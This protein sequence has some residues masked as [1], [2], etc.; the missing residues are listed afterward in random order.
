MDKKG[1]L[2]RYKISPNTLTFEN[3]LQEET[4]IEDLAVSLKTLKNQGIKPP[5]VLDL[6]KVERANSAGILVW[7]KFLMMI[8][9]PYKYVQCPTWL[10]SQF[11][12]IAGYFVNGGFV[13]SIQAPFYNPENEFS[14]IIT[15]KLGIDVPIQENYHEFKMPKRMIEGNEYEPDFDPNRYFSFIAKN[16]KQF[17][18]SIK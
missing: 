1:A 15:L 4:R 17:K 14:K 7:L 10:V 12:M 3:V 6:S 18:A 5:L 16:F 9:I 13:E 2:L 11:N 8:D